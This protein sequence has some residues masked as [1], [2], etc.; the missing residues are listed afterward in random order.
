MNMDDL[1]S[2]WGISSE[3]PAP[4]P[5][6]PADSSCRSTNSD[7][8]DAILGLWG[9]S[10]EGTE[11]TQSDSVT[12]PQELA[13]GTETTHPGSVTSPQE[14]A[15]SLMARRRPRT[16]TNPKTIRQT[17]LRAQKRLEAPG[18]GGSQGRRTPGRG[19]TIPS[20]SG[21]CVGLTGAIFV[22]EG[23]DCT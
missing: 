1:L 16:S 7:P 15:D 5:A 4:T 22:S 6:A 14:L 21:L 2:A 9:F 10:R 8:L 18:A 19:R 23:V 11:T 17:E 20:S 3:A 13:E 12:S